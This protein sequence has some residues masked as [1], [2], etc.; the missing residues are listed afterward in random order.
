MGVMVEIIVQE[1][2]SLVIIRLITKTLLL[3]GKEII[4]S[5]IAYIKGA[6]CALN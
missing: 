2:D 6:K 5:K 1:I 4:I 3:Q